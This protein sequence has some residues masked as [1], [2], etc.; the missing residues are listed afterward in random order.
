[1]VEILIVHDLFEPLDRSLLEH[2]L[3]D[4]V[5]QLLAGE[6][7]VGVAAGLLGYPPERIAALER[8]GAIEAPGAAY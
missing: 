2:D 6:R 8:A 4:D 3:A 5:L 1:V 7:A